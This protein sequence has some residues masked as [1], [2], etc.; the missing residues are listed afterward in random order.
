MNT[1]DDYQIYASK[2]KETGTREY[3]CKKFEDSTKLKSKLIKNPSFIEEQYRDT[4]LL[5]TG[6]C[7][8]LARQ[9][10]NLA[11]SITFISLSLGFFLVF[12]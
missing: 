2:H 3:L 1:I 4:I 8:R 9:D 10:D 7:F 11:K 12:P 5:R 6:V